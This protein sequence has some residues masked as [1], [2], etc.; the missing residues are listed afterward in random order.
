[1]S[2]FGKEFKE[3][4]ILEDSSVERMFKLFGVSYFE[5]VFKNFSEYDPTENKE[6][7]EWT[8]KTYLKNGFLFKDLSEL[9]VIL[10]KFHKN[11]IK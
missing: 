8:I 9:Y 5:E 4:I 7:L 3:K 6:Y 11:K 1:M 10:E 2:K